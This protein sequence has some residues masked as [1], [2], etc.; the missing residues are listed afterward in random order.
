[1]VFTYEEVKKACQKAVDEALN[2]AENKSQFLFAGFCFIRFKGLANKNKL[3]K[4]GFDV[5]KH[6]ESGFYINAD[7]LFEAPGFDQSMILKEIAGKVAC[8]MLEKSGINCWLE[9][10]TD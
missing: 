6:H 7:D 2:K 9:S 4:A 3:V 1:M 5:Q 10:F 8:S